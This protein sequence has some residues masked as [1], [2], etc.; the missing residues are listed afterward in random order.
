VITIGYIEV[1]CSQD[2]AV[3][4]SCFIPPQFVHVCT[5]QHFLF[6]FIVPTDDDDG[7]LVL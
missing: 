2:L 4:S 1:V 3:V 5:V 6:H 7:P